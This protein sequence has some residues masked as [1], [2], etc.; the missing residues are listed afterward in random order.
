MNKLIERKAFTDAMRVKSTGLKDLLS[1]Y[2]RWEEH[3]LQCSCLI[4]D[5]DFTNVAAAYRAATL[6][7]CWEKME[8]EEKKRRLPEGAIKTKNFP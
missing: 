6:D 8:Q 1:L 3:T 4:A 2:N 7:G 5:S